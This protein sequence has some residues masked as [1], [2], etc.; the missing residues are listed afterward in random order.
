MRVYDTATYTAI[1]AISR[2]GMEINGIMIIKFQCI[3][4]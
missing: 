3:I 4:K 2:G 1:A